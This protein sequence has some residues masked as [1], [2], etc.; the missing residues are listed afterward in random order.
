MNIEL[1]NMPGTNAPANNT[2]SSKDDHDAGKKGKKNQKDSEKNTAKD[3]SQSHNKNS[4][5][6]GGGKGGSKSSKD[7]SEK[8]AIPKNATSSAKADADNHK[9]SGRTS[10]NEGKHDSKDIKDPPP[11]KSNS[12]NAQ[13]ESAVGQ[14]RHSQKEVD[15]KQK[16]MNTPQREGKKERKIS[17]Q[18]SPNLEVKSHQKDNSTAGAANTTTGNTNSSSN[19]NSASTSINQKNP[20]LEELPEFFLS[21]LLVSSTPGLGDMF[22][23][24]WIVVM[25]V[26]VGEEVGLLV[27]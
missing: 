12:T 17:A 23:E 16:K 4:D 10:V 7:S 1:N 22:P 2:S 18:N 27:L 13:S 9:S 6:S 8:N 25:V 21:T 19:N 5:R 20:L 15:G 11:A 24:I 26:S 14:K 3:S